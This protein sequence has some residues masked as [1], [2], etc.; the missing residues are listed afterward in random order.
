[1]PIFWQHLLATVAEVNNIKISI[2]DFKTV[3][4]NASQ[5]DYKEICRFSKESGDGN[6]QIGWLNDQV[7]T[8][9]ENNKE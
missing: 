7:C 9:L 2:A 1:M 3:D 5:E 8:Y 4:T 6:F